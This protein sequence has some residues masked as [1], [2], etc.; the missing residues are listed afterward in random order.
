MTTTTVTTVTLGELTIPV[1]ANSVLSQKLTPLDLNNDGTVSIADVPNDPVTNPYYKACHTTKE[2]DL[3]VAVANAFVDADIITPSQKPAFTRLPEVYAAVKQFNRLGS[4]LLN[5]STRSIWT[6]SRK[7]TSQ[8]WQAVLSD[9]S[10][11]TSPFYNEGTDAIGQNF[12]HNLFDVVAGLS[13]QSLPGQIAF[14]ENCGEYSGL[15]YNPKTVPPLLQ[16]ILAEITQTYSPIATRMRRSVR[17]DNQVALGCSGDHCSKFDRGALYFVYPFDLASAD[18][19]LVF[20]GSCY[21]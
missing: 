20:A 16:P 4:F 15:Y 21:Q 5:N 8:D 11:K 12:L 2:T 10:D 6:N 1:P 9:V 7:F 13:A 14:G 18:R 19:N 17:Y 3:I